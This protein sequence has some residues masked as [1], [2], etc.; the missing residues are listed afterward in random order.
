[1]IDTQIKESIDMSLICIIAI[2]NLSFTLPLLSLQLKLA[3]S[4]Q[5]LEESF[6]A[7]SWKKGRGQISPKKFRVTL[8]EK[9]TTYETS[10]QEQSGGERYLISFQRSVLEAAKNEGINF[11]MWNI[12]LYER[13]PLSRGYQHKNLLQ[14]YEPG[15]GGDHLPRENTIADLAPLTKPMFLKGMALYPS[16]ETPRFGIVG[17]PLTS[18]RVIKVEDFYCVI[19]VTNV[20]LN[21]R[22][23]GR[24]NSLEVDIEFTNSY[25]R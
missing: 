8:D 15:P 23:P 6:Y 11:E 13:D 19:R 4:V 10:I 24:F 2:F 16:K 3:G 9:I 25:Q 5:A 18:T 12:K 17:Y 20:E 14:P 21:R 1:V 22:D 7:E